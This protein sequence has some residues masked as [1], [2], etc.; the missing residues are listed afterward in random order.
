[1]SNK[2]PRCDECGEVFSNIFEATDHFLEEG[3]PE[4]DPALILPGGFHL[5]I[6]SLLRHLYKN[7]SKPKQ[8]RQIVESVYSTLYAS[9]TNPVQVEDIIQDMVVDSHM[10]GF[11][12]ELFNLLK[13]K[14]PTNEEN[15]A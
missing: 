2:I 4:F 1:M 12:D 5:M 9:E 8:I 10:V 11:D 7:S 3:E 15:G 6:G 13:G 14:E